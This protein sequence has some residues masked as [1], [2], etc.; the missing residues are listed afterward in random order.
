MADRH[1]RSADVSTGGP[2]V[3]NSHARPAGATASTGVLDGRSGGDA[4]VPPD[5]RHN[6]GALGG[7]GSL[8]RRKGFGA[9]SAFRGLTL[10]AGT[11][12]LVIIVA[13]TV[14]LIAK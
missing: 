9:E 7:G 2:G 11:M 14:F 8:P 1:T 6:G 10:A 12:V 3:T 13:I 5:L 4:P